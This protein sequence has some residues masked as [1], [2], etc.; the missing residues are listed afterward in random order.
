MLLVCRRATPQLLARAW[1][2]LGSHYH[3]PSDVIESDWE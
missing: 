3:R 2:W 1:Q